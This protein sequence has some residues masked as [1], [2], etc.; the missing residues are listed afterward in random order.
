MCTFLPSCCRKRRKRRGRKKSL[1]KHKVLKTRRGLE[2]ERTKTDKHTTKRRRVALRIH[3]TGRNRRRRWWRR[4]LRFVFIVKCTQWIIDGE[5]TSRYC[6][7]KLITISIIK[8]CD[9]RARRPMCL[10]SFLLFN[11]F[12][13]SP[14]SLLNFLRFLIGIC[15]LSK[16]YPTLVTILPAGWKCRVLKN[17]AVNLNFRWERYFFMFWEF[18]FYRKEKTSKLNS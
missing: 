8:A 11:L 18:I 15:L 7:S 10:L 12:C 1:G 14:N 17:H 2:R 4:W 3:T 9:I 6:F 16:Y 13:Y 5:S